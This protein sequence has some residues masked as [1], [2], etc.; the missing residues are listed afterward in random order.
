MLQ[1]DSLSSAFTRAEPA[2]ARGRQP[3]TH[4]L[5]STL[6]SRRLFPVEAATARADRPVS[7]S[8]RSTVILPICSTA[9]RKNCGLRGANLHRTGPPQG[10]SRDLLIRAL[11]HHLQE[12]AA[13]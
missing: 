7:T 13:G 4:R 5:A 9:R 6:A 12:R 3:T 11:A 2:N 1:V 10:L 8:P